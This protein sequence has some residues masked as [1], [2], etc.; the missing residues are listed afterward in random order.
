M[1]RL[2]NCIFWV[3]GILV[4]LSASSCTDDTF[5]TGQGTPDGVDMGRTV[6]VTIPFKTGKGIAADIQTRAG[7][8][9]SQLSGIMVFIYENT[10]KPET[11]RRVGWYL[12]SNPANGSLET[13]RADG[14]R[15]VT[16]QPVEN[17]ISRTRG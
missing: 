15:I 5:P 9:D 1:N 11:D 12:F 16:I 2:R 4:I 8:P 14:Y 17:K 6:E 7:G 10:G 3:A 13:V